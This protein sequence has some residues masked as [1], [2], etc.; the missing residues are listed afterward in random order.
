MYTV[1]DLT[2][3]FKAYKYAAYSRSKTV[4][5]GLNLHN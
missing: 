3:D 2:F 5:D 4:F 1:D